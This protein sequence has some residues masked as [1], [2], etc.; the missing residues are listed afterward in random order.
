MLEPEQNVF[1]QHKP[2]LISIVEQLQKGSLSQQ[3]YPATSPFDFKT[4]S[5]KV[6][7]FIVGG[8]TYVEAKELNSMKNVILGSTTLLSSATF[9][10]GV[11][12]LSEM[13]RNDTMLNLEIE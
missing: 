4:P 12:S 8:A 11:A 2:F 7:V 13:K 6:I 5:P 9:L 3:Q 1:L 10:S